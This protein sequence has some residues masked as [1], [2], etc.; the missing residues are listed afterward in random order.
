M[1]KP[2][3]DMNE[4]T[5]I[6]VEDLNLDDV[7][8][9][10]TADLTDTH[11][12]FLT[13]NQSQLTETQQTKFGFGADGGEGGED[14]GGEDEGGEDE[15]K[16]DEYNPDAVEPGVKTPIKFDMGE[17][18]DDDDMDAEDRARIN[19]QVAKGSKGIIARQQ[20]AEDTQAVNNI[21]S[22]KPELKAYKGLTLKYMKAHP[23]LTAEDAMKIASAGDQQRIGAA[24]ERV[25]AAK[26]KK[27]QSGGNSYRSSGGG[28]TKDWGSATNDEMEAQ[29][30]S[31]K[32][33]R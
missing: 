33:Q 28:G 11:R 5:E 24:K 27:T 15:E 19:K 7:V 1:E 26:V 31:S 23:S 9:M 4:E 18:D 30:A 29:I 25:A 21:V 2:K 6:V 32:G 8:N 14:E 12:E 20:L 22:D 13:D 16:K 3:A 10:D 17:D